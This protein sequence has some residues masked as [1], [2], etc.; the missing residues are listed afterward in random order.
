MLVH[1]KKGKIEL[2]AEDKFVAKILFKIKVLQ[3]KGQTFED[4]F[5]SVM[6]KANSEFQAVKAYGNIGDRKNDGFM[7]LTHAASIQSELEEAQTIDEEYLKAF[8]KAY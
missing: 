1:D 3:F 6:S 5:V 7:A 8:M 2:R 4:F